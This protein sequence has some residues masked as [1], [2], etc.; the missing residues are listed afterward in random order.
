MIERSSRY[1]INELK[2]E[3]KEPDLKV[4]DRKRHGRRRRGVQS[5]V[6]E[7]S[8]RKK[9]AKMSAEHMTSTKQ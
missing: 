9:Q 6:N 1:Y 7:F 2:I 3:R 8:N 5:I 4:M